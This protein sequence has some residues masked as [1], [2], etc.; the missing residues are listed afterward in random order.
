MRKM[1]A[2]MGV[3]ELVLFHSKFRATN[4]RRKTSKVSKIALL[5]DRLLVLSLFFPCSWQL[6]FGWG[7][8]KWWTKREIPYFVMA[9]G[10][11]KCTPNTWI[12]SRCESFRLVIALRFFGCFF[13]FWVIEWNKTSSNNNNLF[14][15][16]EILVLKIN[17]FCNLNEFHSP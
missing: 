6:S 10:W 16:F 8:T 15:Y 12:T 11:F 1:S 2:W 5:L 13:F 3:L 4:A 9:R 14:K 17:I 7:N